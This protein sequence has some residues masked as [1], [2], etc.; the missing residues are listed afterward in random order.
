[1][2]L[3]SPTIVKVEISFG[4]DILVKDY[5][6]KLVKSLLISGN[7][8]LKDVFARRESLP[9]KPIHITPLYT[10]SIDRSS[11][12]KRERKV[13]AVYSRIV[14][15]GS[16]ARPPTVDEIRP[17]RIEAGRRYFFYVGTNIALL[18]EVLLGLSNIDGFVFGRER[19]FVDQLSYEIR[20][21]DVERNSEEILETLKTARE[22]RMRVVFNSPTLL[23]DPLVV[24]RRRKRKLLLPL[25]E[26]I[27]STPLLMVLIDK[28]MV[29]KSI[30]M[31]CMIY[32]K[33]I[34]DIPYTALKTINLVWYV[35]DNEVLPAMIGYIKYFIDYQTLQ[36][37][38]SVMEI[39]C[40]LDFMELLSKTT[41][42]A[43]VYG[44][45]D[46]RATGFGH[47]TIKINKTRK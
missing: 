26:A 17:V 32:V 12:E 21:V 43:Q 24:M 41:I 20:Y 6:A 31:R 22:K 13:E 7:P 44:V 40:G 34:L 35:Y 23:K 15:R 46:G 14:P 45:G 19:V 33:S 10:Y 42:L 30:F 16:S 38:Q 47:V 18:N 11:E 29:R 1:M 28:G 4:N 27:L 39:K 25:P 3:E 9:P 2:Y 5:T 8:N 36:Y 37:A